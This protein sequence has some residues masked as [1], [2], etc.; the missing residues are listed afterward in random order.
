M[1][2]LLAGLN[3]QKRKLSPG[4]RRH[5]QCWKTPE[6]RRFHRKYP[7]SSYFA[8]RRKGWQEK[9]A[10]TSM[11]RWSQ[12]QLSLCFKPSGGA[13]VA[14]GE[15]PNPLA[16]RSRPWVAGPT[17]PALSATHASPLARSPSPPPSPAHPRRCRSG[18]TVPSASRP[19]RRWAASPGRPKVYPTWGGTIPTEWCG[20]ATPGGTR[21][22]PAS[23]SG[24][25]SAGSPG[26]HTCLRERG[27]GGGGHWSLSL[28][29]LLLCIWP[30]PWH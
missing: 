18:R 15:S 12:V 16:W 9:P 29:S 5:L 22:P 21:G 8:E 7:R 23:G 25:W 27:V 26:A 10:S 14:S 30:C 2:D 11:W 4:D 28:L 6:G 1:E 19:S 17:T 20:S 13:P 24:S 3:L